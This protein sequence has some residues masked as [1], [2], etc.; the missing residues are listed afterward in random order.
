MSL[1]AAHEDNNRTEKKTWFSH[2]EMVNVL[3]K[4]KHFGDDRQQAELNFNTSDDRYHFDLVI[5]I[6]SF[7]DKSLLVN[8]NDKYHVPLSSLDEGIMFY[9]GNMTSNACE[10]EYII[11]TKVTREG[12]DAVIICDNQFYYLEPSS[13]YETSGKDK[14]QQYTAKSSTYLQFWCIFY[15]SSDVQMD[16]NGARIYWEGRTNL[17]QI[18]D[19]IEVISNG[20]YKRETR[21]PLQTECTLHVVADYK[22]YTNT[23]HS[24]I[25]TTI[26]EM[27]YIILQANLIFRGTDFDGDGSGDNIGFY[28][29]DISIYTESDTYKMANAASV[30]SYLEKFSEYDFSDYCLATSFTSQNFADGVVGLAWVGSSNIH[31][32]GGICQH[33]IVYKS[34]GMYLN[35]NLI[36]TMNRDR[37]I[38]A[39]LSSL[40][41]A[42]EFGHSFGSPHDDLNNAVC[43]PAGGYGN[44]LMYPYASEGG[45]PNNN[46]FSPCSINYMYPVIR[47]K[48][49]CLKQTVASQCGNGVRE[50]NEECDCG[51]TVTCVAV[52]PCCTPSDV[53]DSDPDHPCT[54]RRSH[55]SRCSPKLSLCCTGDCKIVTANKVCKAQSDCTEQS[56]CD[57][58]SSVCPTEVKLPDKLPCASGTKSCTGG[59]CVGSICATINQNPCSCLNENTCY[60]CCL[61]SLSK[62][63]PYKNDKNEK[64]ALTSGIS[65]NAK[66]GFCNGNGECISVDETSTMDRFKQVFTHEEVDSVTNWLKNQWYYIVIAVVVV[67]FLV[68]MFIKTCRKDRTVQT[69]AY[70]Y[71]RLTGIEREAELQKVYLQ[72]RRLE[73]K[74][75]YIKKINATEN[76]SFQIDFPTAVARMMVFF[77][78]AP[79]NV[80]VRILKSSSSE[81][82][83]VRWLLLRN[84]PFRRFCKN[85]DKI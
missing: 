52:D 51:T 27:S 25:R 24:D 78:T 65:C 83:A 45:K 55:G 1:T 44:Y 13:R 73:I 62:C 77:P 49:T 60:T 5:Q 22:F 4:N 29:S 37:K 59:L 79:M 39:Y 35:T 54:F 74:E 16:V 10:T 18:T 12:L 23:G 48:G 76:F 85:I 6:P 64:L 15:K 32:P 46:I 36:T 66:H 31:G 8:V 19:D 72:R 26:A 56:V 50:K 84:Y 47:N 43:T 33:R 40:I 34:K 21:N 41:L 7:L 28:I 68:L 63:V 67:S 61:N 9:K 17:T 3:V 81:E 71:G 20:R 58:M 69:S 57:G 14:T 82:W 38:P 80:I 53:S 11:H 2:Y 70:M 75:R 30:E 42:H